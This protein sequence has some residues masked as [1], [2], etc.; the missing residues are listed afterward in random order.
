[1]PIDNDYFK[2]DNNKT[3]EVQMVEETI[4]HLFETPEILKIL[5]KAGILC[6]YHNYWCTIFI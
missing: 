6:S 2:T 1:M 4:N 5:E 3:M